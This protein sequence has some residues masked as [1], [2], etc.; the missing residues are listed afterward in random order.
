[1]SH[2]NLH[3]TQLGSGPDIV[4]LHGWG[5]YSGIW[6]SLVHQL[7]LDFRVT[8]IDLPGHGHSQPLTEEKSLAEI[9]AMVAAVVPF[10][11]IWLGWS[12]GGLIG[13]Y[14]AIHQLAIVNKLILV[15]TTPKFTTTDDWP[16][17]TN[18][19]IFDSFSARLQKN[20]EDTLKRFSLLQN[21]GLKGI[22]HLTKELIA[23]TKVNYSRGDSL[24]VMLNILKEEDLREEMIKIK[25]SLSFI[26]G[27]EDR[28]VPSELGNWIQVQIPL[29]QLY[30]LDNAGHILFLSH[31]KEFWHTLQLILN[32]P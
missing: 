26:L 10:P 4:L 1:M 3:I 11:A 29:S 16:Y 24:G 14:I 18:P 22:A 21:Q 25:C 17:G 19:K 12:L 30:L 8:L 5:F 6:R 13:L 20:P 7:S 2:H 32:H 15:A 23:E 27:K 9:S 31:S 28:L